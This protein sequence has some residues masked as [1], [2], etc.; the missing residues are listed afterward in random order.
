MPLKCVSMCVCVLIATCRLWSPLLA[1]SR[2]S[3]DEGH[4]VAC[5]PTLGYMWGQLPCTCAFCAPFIH[6]LIFRAINPP[7]TLLLMCILQGFISSVFWPKLWCQIRWLCGRVWTCVCVCVSK[8][9]VTPLKWQA[10]RERPGWR[11]LDEDTRVP[12]GKLLCRKLSD[13][14]PVSPFPSQ[15]TKYRYIYALTAA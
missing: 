5:S 9:E 2:F 14:Q 8:P 15:G 10:Q 6:S 4:E 13:N 3:P 12:E 1:D 7:P 11:R